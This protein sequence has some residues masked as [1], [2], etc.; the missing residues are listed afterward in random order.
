MVEFRDEERGGAWHSGRPASLLSS[1]KHAVFRE[2]ILG[3]PRKMGRAL[4]SLAMK[5][6]DRALVIWRAAGWFRMM[7]L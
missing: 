5:W 2:I 1:L 3:S 4:S 6:S 7:T